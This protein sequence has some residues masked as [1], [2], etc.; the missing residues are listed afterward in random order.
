M[1]I[2]RQD[3]IFICACIGEDMVQTVTGDGGQYVME[4]KSEGANL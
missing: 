2:V 3:Y 4:S 1:V